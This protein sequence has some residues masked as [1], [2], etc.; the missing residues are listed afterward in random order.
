[1]INDLVYTNFSQQ[2]LLNHIC[3]P[4][5]NFIMLHQYTEQVSTCS[6]H[7]Q[8]QLHP[9]L[10]PITTDAFSGDTKLVCEEDT[11]HPSDI[12]YVM[13]CYI[14]QAVLQITLFIF[15]LFF[16]TLFIFM[17]CYDMP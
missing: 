10:L 4:P 13:T 11:A 2:R 16:Y 17:S 1:M 12:T 9:T 5:P 6:N 14:T 3:P 15:T 8:S 7:N